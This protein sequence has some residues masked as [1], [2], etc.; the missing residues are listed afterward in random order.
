MVGNSAGLV[1]YYYT[2]TK[3][4]FSKPYL[5]CVS[6]C[7]CVCVCVHVCVCGK[8]LAP[9]LHQLQHASYTCIC[10]DMGQ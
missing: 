9:R 8:T 1:D 2:K 6:L 7:V 5:L 4:Q 3:I 10:Q